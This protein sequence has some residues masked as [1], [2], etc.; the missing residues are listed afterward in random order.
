MVDYVILVAVEYIHCNISNSS[1]PHK[2]YEINPIK[3]DQ[4]KL[5]NIE[6]T[7][8]IQLNQLQTKI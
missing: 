1:K 7:P 4:I 3:S 8:K 6:S 2:W 5:I